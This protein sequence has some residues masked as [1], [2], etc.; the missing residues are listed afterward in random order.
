MLLSPNSQRIENWLGVHEV[1]KLQENMKG[2]Y[3][4]PIQVSNVPGRLFVGKDGDFRGHIEGG[5][6]AT[7]FDKMYDAYKRRDVS[8]QRRFQRFLKKHRL[9]P[10][11]H[12]FSSLSDL[13]A[14]ASAGKKQSVAFQKVGTTG[15][16][17]STNSLWGVGN[18]PVAGV[19]AL[20]APG[21]L[22]HVMNQVGS[23]NFR[24]PSSPDTLHVVGG[25][26]LS[27][28]A[29]NQLLLYD[30]L[31]S[32][33]KNMNTTT[34]EA[35]TGTPTRYQNTTDSQPDSIEGNFMFMECVTALAATAHNWVTCTYVDNHGAS[36]TMASLAGNASNIVNRLDM[37]AGMWFAPLAPGD[38]GVKS[39]TQIQVSAAVATGSAN[40]VIGHPI[41]WFP[42]PLANV[43]IPTDL[44]AGPFGLERVLDDMCGAF[45]E[46]CKSVT[47]ATTYTGVVTAVA[48]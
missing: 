9:N 32:V 37:P 15:V 18:N 42:C 44:I 27:S 39:I 38:A 34:A 48:G 41:A 6:H 35:V 29:G 7:I 1:E 46:V 26:V 13:I 3:G 19:A 23:F 16:V 30:R 40:V 24:N 25:Q 2:W 8:V 17:N 22:A 28:V 11:L 4:P 14:E 36:S 47:T 31:F 12:G 20:A 33:L 21:G 5:S 10:A 45:L 43:L